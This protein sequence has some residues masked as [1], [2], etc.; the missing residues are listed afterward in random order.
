MTATDISLLTVQ[1]VGSWFFGWGIGK[2]YY[3][4]EVAWHDW[5]G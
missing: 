4:V 1:L 2:I 5:M 3:V